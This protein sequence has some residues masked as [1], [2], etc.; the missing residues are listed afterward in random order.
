MRIEHIA[1]WTVNL[2][3]LKNFYVKYFGAKAGLLYTNKKTGFQSYFLEFKE[4]CRLEII[5][6]PGI[7]EQTNN[8]IGLAHFAIS[9]GSKE[10][11]ES[12]TNRLR[13]EGYKVLSEPRVTG[14]GYFESVISDP[15]G[16]RVEITI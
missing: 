11:V 9:V 5:Q 12:L 4:G 13:D 8:G 15:D 7:V 10:D 1:I 14:D 2:E 16:N 6:M 3:R